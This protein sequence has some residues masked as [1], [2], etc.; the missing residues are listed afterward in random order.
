M[1]DMQETEHRVQISTNVLWELIHVIR[2][3]SVQI[4]YDRIVVLVLCDMMVTEKL[5]WK[6]VE[7]ELLLLENPVMMEIQIL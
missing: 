3:L 6:F 7:I 4:Q 2:L 1:R 5:V